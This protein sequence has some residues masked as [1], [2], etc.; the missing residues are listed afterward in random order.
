M[1]WCW[2][3]GV[4]SATLAGCTDETQDSNPPTVGSA[5]T[6]DPA[7]IRFDGE[8]V[9]FPASENAPLSVTSDAV[10]SNGSDRLGYVVANVGAA[11]L[12]AVNSDAPKHGASTG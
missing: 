10:A 12:T 6:G 2:I 8:V 3:A 9:D 7:Q 4:L 11:T 1:I 5:K